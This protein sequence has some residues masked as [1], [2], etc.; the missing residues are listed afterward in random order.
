[1][2]NFIR[3]IKTESPDKMIFMS[4]E[5]LRLAVKDYPEYWNHY[6]PYAGLGG[7]LVM[8]YSQDVT[9]PLKKSVI[10]RRTAPRMPARTDG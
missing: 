8:P 5:Q 6:R 4:G 3:A 1:M 9:E 2:E 7:K 10:L